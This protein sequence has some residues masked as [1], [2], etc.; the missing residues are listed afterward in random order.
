MKDLARLLKYF[1]DLKQAMDIIYPEKLTWDN[2]DKYNFDLDYKHPQW[3]KDHFPLIMIYHKEKAGALRD[4][5]SLKVMYQNNQNIMTQVVMT[6]DDF[7]MYHRKNEHKGFKNIVAAITATKDD[8]TDSPYYDLQKPKKFK[9]F[10]EFANIHAPED[11]HLMIACE[12]LD[13]YYP[14]DSVGQ[15]RLF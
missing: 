14:C 4:S 11:K 5:K 9:N 12:E 7:G 10:F 13:K 1:E 8:L 3:V 15:I 2:L 6:A